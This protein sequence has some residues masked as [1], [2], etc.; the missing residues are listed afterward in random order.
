MISLFTKLDDLGPLPCFKINNSYTF[1]T[2]IGGL[3]TMITYFLIFGLVCYFLNLLFSRNVYTIVYNNVYDSDLSLNITDFPHM[4]RVL[5][6]DSQPLPNDTRYYYIHSELLVVETDGTVLNRTKK[7]IKHEKC[8]IDKHFGKYRE[9]FKD[10]PFLESYYCMV[11][12]QIDLTL[13]TPMGT[14]KNQTY[15]V[16][17]V[18]RCSNETTAN[19]MNCYDTNTINNFLMSAY[20]SYVSLEYSMNHQNISSPGKLH[21]VSQLLSVSTTTYTRYIYNIRPILYSTDLG[22][23]FE[24]TNYQN[25]F[26]KGDPIFFTSLN[27]QTVLVP[28][29]FSHVILTMD[30][31]YDTYT[32]SYMKFQTVI[33][34]AG[35]VMKGL[36]TF[37]KMAT[38]FFTNSFY[39]FELVTALFNVEI[40]PQQIKLM[41][42]D[43]LSFRKSSDSDR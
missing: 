22:Y 12:G 17:H 28:G 35:G 13:N 1:Q 4:I 36:L 38:F 20:V 3:L 16:N 9:Y 10:V 8:N 23:V 30:N 21:L 43:N 5:K 7:L 24:D 40:V 18:V 42:Y 27:T 19:R 33:A 37:S 11:P 29:T 2:F 15:I 31:K 34:N 32:R 41:P 14:V 6:S 25:Y 39:Y 26:L